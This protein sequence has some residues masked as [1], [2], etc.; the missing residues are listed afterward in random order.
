MI[1]YDAILISKQLA[2]T[3]RSFVEPAQNSRRTLDA[4]DDYITS[5]AVNSLGTYFSLREYKGY[6]ETRE[7]NLQ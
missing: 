7:L 3:H 6:Q 2:V 1:F 5:N 4:G